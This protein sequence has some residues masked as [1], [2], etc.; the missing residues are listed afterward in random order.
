MNNNCFCKS[1]RVIRDTPSLYTHCLSGGNVLTLAI[2][3]LRIR[4]FSCK[5][6]L[7]SSIEVWEEYDNLERE[8]TNGR[9]LNSGSPECSNK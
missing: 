7:M 8:I 2:R 9:T 6:V 5:V 3:R 1:C 4:C